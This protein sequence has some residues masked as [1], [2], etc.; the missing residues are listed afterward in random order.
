[1]RIG[2]LGCGKLGSPI[3]DVLNSAHIVW[4][5][6]IDPAKTQVSTVADA[7]LDADVV[8][9]AVQTPHAPEYEGITRAPVETQPFEL[10][11][12]RTAVVQVVK[13]LG[14]RPVPIV[15]V[16]TVLPGDCRRELMPLLKGQPL[17]YNPAFIAM[18]TVKEDFLHPEF[19]LL[20]SDSE[21]AAATVA[22]VYREIGVGPFRFMSLESAELVK[23]AYNT[24]I[25]QKIVFANALMEICDRLPGA[26]VDH[27]TNALIA[28]FKRIAS[29]RYLDA[30][31]GDGGPCHPRDNIAMAH[32]AERLN[33]S[34]DPFSY[35]TRAREAQTGWLA[36]K[37][38]NLAKQHGLPLV[39]LGRPYKVG[40]DIET[41]SCGLLLAS[42]LDERGESYSWDDRTSPPVFVACLPIAQQVPPG[43]V[44]LDPWNCAIPEAGVEIVAVGR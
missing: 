19:V 1:M 36:T 12:L 39:L 3:V 41:G 26:N 37:A 22:K 7:C 10:S 13:A 20:G 16:S 25:S 34:A 2:W 6:D 30:G 4:A 9:I 5:Y 42:I 43:S 23:V 17:V 44:I 28:A 35:V 18:G 29:G 11:Y 14:N 15:I 32:L 33:L 8:F 31:M 38:V 21:T 24:F 40:V 27:V